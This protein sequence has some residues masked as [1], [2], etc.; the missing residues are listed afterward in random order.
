MQD[1]A[2]AWNVASGQER[3]SLP[4]GT[5]LATLAAVSPDSKTLALG[6][7]GARLTLCDLASGKEKFPEPTSHKQ[8]ALALT[9]SNDGRTLA[10]AGS[11]GDVQVKLWDVGQAKERSVIS[12]QAVF[13]TGFMTTFASD[14]QTVLTRTPQ[15]FTAWSLTTGR[16]LG[17]LS[18][19]NAATVQAVMAPTGKVL[20][21]F[22]VAESSI[23]LW[24]LP[25]F[26]PL[27]T[28]P[29]QSQ[30]FVIWPA[31]SGD[32]Q[33]VAT[34]DPRGKARLWDTA[35]GRE[36]SSSLPAIGTGFFTMA[37]SRDG[38]LLASGSEGTVRLWDAHT[39]QQRLSYS[40]SANRQGAVYT[41]EFTGSELLASNA[42]E[43]KVWDLSGKE[44]VTPRPF[45]ENSTAVALAPD[46]KLL[47][48]VE[49]GNTLLV[50]D[51]VAG[52]EVRRV[53]LPGPANRVAFAADSR[54]LATANT[55]GTI[56]VLRVG[57]GG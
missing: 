29:G 28:L 33:V 41:L 55:N 7:I 13:N 16:E 18:M 38:K 36:L 8:G 27:A 17:K 52:R 30:G 47:A 10:S 49:P 44:K 45:N 48:V 42:Q 32:G 31:F 23:K 34:C 2:K 50:W 39:G 5:G 21:T 26:R 9:F 1:Q 54:H 40:F 56:Y 6:G 19:A 57:G 25:S 4:G 46:G 3:Y 12:E 37:L 15:G 35:S 24:E 22:G 53:A 51:L 11:H 20:A 14:R 43:V